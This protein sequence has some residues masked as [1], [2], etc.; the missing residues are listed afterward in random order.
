MVDRGVDAVVVG[1]RA[2]CPGNEPRTP[3]SYNPSHRLMTNA[4]LEFWLIHSIITS[5][6]YRM[7]KGGEGSE[8]DII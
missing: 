3:S 8:P 1:I 7:S 4:I 5:I 2:G 6:Y